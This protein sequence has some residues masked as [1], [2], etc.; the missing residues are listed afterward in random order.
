MV[1]GQGAGCIVM[2]GWSHQ[3]IFVGIGQPLDHAP[4]GVLSLM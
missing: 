3:P 2:A 1:F 4:L